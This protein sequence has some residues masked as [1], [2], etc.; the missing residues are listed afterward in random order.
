MENAYLIWLIKGLSFVE[1]ILVLYA[2]ANILQSIWFRFYGSRNISDQ[3]KREFYVEKKYD[4]KWTFS[5]MVAMLFGSMVSL[6]SG[7]RE[8]VL[9]M[10]IC[11]FLFGLL[12]WGAYRTLDID[13]K[14]LDRKKGLGI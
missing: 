12:L 10:L 11:A 6:L 14:R 7:R 9:W 4:I 5:M 1:L 3:E 2:T 13:K 8:E